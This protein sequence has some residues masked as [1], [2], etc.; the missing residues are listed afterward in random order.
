MKGQPW[1]DVPDRAFVLTVR[2]LEPLAPKEV[3]AGGETASV[4]ARKVT[5]ALRERLLAALAP[6]GARP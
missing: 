6:A 3:L 4:A 2:V 1:Y 5:D